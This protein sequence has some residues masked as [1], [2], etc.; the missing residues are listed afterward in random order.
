LILKYL[1]YIFNAEFCSKRISHSGPDVEDQAIGH[2]IHIIGFPP[3][4]GVDPSVV[5][6]FEEVKFQ[7]V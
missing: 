7:T 5:E 2:C 1:T 6:Y 4:E 3:V